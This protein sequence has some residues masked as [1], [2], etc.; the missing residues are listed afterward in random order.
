MYS[1]IGETADRGWLLHF[2]HFYF[3]YKKAILF[4]KTASVKHIKHLL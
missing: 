3:N 4:F 1:R 2:L